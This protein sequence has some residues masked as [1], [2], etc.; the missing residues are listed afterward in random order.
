LQSE[1]GNEVIDLANIT[2]APQFKVLLAD[3]TSSPG[4]HDAGFVQQSCTGIKAK[5]ASCFAC[6]HSACGHIV[7][8]PASHAL[9]WP[10]EA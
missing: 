8:D 3:L 1:P 6:E 10:D 7:A 4:E 2:A 5:I 9:G